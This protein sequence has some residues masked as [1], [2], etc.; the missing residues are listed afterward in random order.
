MKTPWEHT[1]SYPE[2]Y[3]TASAGATS[4]GLERGATAQQVQVL[5]DVSIQGQIVNLLEDVQDQFGLTYLFISHDLGMIQHV[6]DRVAVMYL[7]KIVENGS[8]EDIYRRAQH[9]YTKALLSSVP[10]PNPKARRERERTVLSGEIPSPTEPP[11]GCRFRTRCPMVEPRCKA[12]PPELRELDRGHEV[13][14]HLS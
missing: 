8:G 1:R 5:L 10:R 11:A 12:H 13:A 2:L 7:G 9:P 4:R 3:L 6:C 14:C